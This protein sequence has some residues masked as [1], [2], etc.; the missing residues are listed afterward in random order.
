MS[1][2]LTFLVSIPKVYV[3]FLLHRHFSTIPSCIY[4]KLG[5]EVPRDLG[6]FAGIALLKIS[7]SIKNIASHF[8]EVLGYFMVLLIVTST[9][10][11]A[12]I[13]SVY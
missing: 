13:N 8:I 2:L 10:N 12:A 7:A 11:K 6:I 5:T 3:N 1:N 4:I 9:F